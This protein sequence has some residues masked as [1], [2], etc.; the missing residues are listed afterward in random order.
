MATIQRYTLK[1]NDET[2]YPDERGRYCLY[3]DVLAYASQVAREVV[4]KINI[5][6]DSYRCANCHT[7]VGD[8]WIVNPC[9]NRLCSHDFWEKACILSVDLEKVK[10]KVLEAYPAEV[11]NGKS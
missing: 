5:D 3:S 4:E 7:K 11:N 1:V 6:T 9:V 10:A 8:T 2:D